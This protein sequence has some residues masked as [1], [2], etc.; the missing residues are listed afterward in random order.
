MKTALLT[1]LAALVPVTAQGQ[2]L[3]QTLD[4]TFTLLCSP[5]IECQEH[6]GVPF[7]FD[8]TE[9]D[10]SFTSNAGTI[11]GRFLPHLQGRAM[12]A[13]F[14]TSDT[15]TLLLTLTPT[16]EAVLTQHDVLP[17]GAV[18]SVSYFGTCAPAT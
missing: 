1:L 15:A 2:S 5:Q 3:S 11:T 7:R 17:S 10:I 4:C 9:N 14:E 12:G 13:L 6:P 18:Q 8:V 16:R